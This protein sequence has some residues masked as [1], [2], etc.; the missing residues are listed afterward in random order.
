MPHW[1]PEGSD[2]VVYTT[3]DE[4]H[5]GSADDVSSYL[6]TLKKDLHI[7]ERDILNTF[8]WVEISKHAIIKNLKSKYPDQYKWLYP[9]PGDWH[10]MKTAAEVI[11]LLYI[12]NIFQTINFLI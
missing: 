3:V 4:A 5:S 12:K 2:K 7:G 11:I 1:T 10:I 8:S 6:F 9:V